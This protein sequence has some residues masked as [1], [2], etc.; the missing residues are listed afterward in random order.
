MTTRPAK[1]PTQRQLRVGEEIRHALAGLIARGE[2]H[3]PALFDVS[4]TVT[5]VRL[6]PDLKAAT[7]FVMPLGGAGVAEVLAGLRRAAPWLRGRLAREVRL[8]FAPELHFT[9]DTAFDNAQRIGAAIGALGLEEEPPAGGGD[10]EGG[11]GA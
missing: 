6:S 5:E 11:D 9:A 4:L 3:D 2:L 8:K 1:E 7:V 10:G